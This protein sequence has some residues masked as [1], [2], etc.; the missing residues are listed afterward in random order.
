MVEATDPDKCWEIASLF[1]DTGI[2]GS[3]LTCETSFLMRSVVRDIILTTIPED[4]QQQC[5]TS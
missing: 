2:P 4:Y 5:I 1:R 3:V